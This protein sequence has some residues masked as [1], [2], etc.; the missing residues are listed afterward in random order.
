M[1]T[2]FK[3]IPIIFYQCRVIEALSA[4]LSWLSFLLLREIVSISFAS[5]IDLKTIEKLENLVTHYLITFDNAYGYTQRLPKHHL[6]VHLGEQMNRFGPLRFTSCMI[7]E[8]KHSFF[9]R[10]KY[11]N[12]RNIAFT[13]ADRHQNYIASLMY[14]CS[15]VNT[16]SFLYSG[17]QIKK[18]KELDSSAAKQHHLLDQ[19]KALYETSRVTLFGITYAVGDA[20]LINDCVFPSDHVFGKI[21]TIIIQDKIILLRLQLMQV[22]MFKQQLC[23]YELRL[24]DVSVTKN[25]YELKHVWPLRLL[26]VS[27]SLFASLFPYGR[28]YLTW[29]E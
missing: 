6:L 5:E 12:F 18:I 28:S 15:N 4:S 3:Y 13:L 19:N 10:I 24:L 9:K 2:L 1:L 25:I 16:S 26:K 29:N 22:I 8:K 11:R 20:V 14:T 17:H 21:L 27:G 23:V 7:F